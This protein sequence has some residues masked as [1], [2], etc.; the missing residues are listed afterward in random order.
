L[1]TRFILDA[2]LKGNPILILFGCATGKQVQLEI[3]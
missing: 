2:G 3:A 1:G